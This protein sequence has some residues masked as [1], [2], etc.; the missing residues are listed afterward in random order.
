MKDFIRR[1]GMNLVIG[2]GDVRV[3][4][5]G[6]NIEYSAG[7]NPF[8]TDNEDDYI[9]LKKVGL[10]SGRLHLDYT[11][12]EDDN[13]PFEYKETGFAFVDNQINRARKHGIN[14]ILDMHY[15][16]CGWQVEDTDFWQAGSE[17]QER[18][19]RMW[20][21]I[22]E[23]YRDEPLVVAYDLINEPKA[24][25]NFAD[26][27]AVLNKT[28]EAIRS[29]DQ[30]H[31]IWI[32]VPVHN[33]EMLPK[34]EDTNI[35]YDFHMYRPHSFTHQRIQGPIIEKWPSLLREPGWFDLKD[36]HVGGEI[37]SPALKEYP[38]S[39]KG[40]EYVENC[41]LPSIEWARKNDYPLV[42]GEFGVASTCVDHGGE[43]WVT[44]V[45]RVLENNDVHY[46]Y[47][48]LRWKAPGKDFATFGLFKNALKK[49][50]PGL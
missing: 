10:N 26:Y 48:S 3:T 7:E 29:V 25:Q 43:E 41:V 23:R 44:D 24:D 20:Q 28:I 38:L 35:I 45:L 9:Q 21:A 1:K 5:R 8:T 34:I 11:Y 42:C 15:A 13:R 49:L 47:Y 27:E 31:L 37:R 50:K 19:I 16:Q 32:E 22:A 33:E 46:Y 12:F 30:N 4:L 17:L 14:I 6:A 40:R 2:A 18:F 39:D 36:L